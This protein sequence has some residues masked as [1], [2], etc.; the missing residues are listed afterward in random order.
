VSSFVLSGGSAT[1]IDA[2]AFHMSL[3]FVF[4]VMQGWQQLCPAFI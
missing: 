1:A 2:D 3:G 4:Q